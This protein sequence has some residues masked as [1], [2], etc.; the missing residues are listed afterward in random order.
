[1]RTY[2]G[3]NKFKMRTSQLKYAV[4]EFKQSLPDTMLPSFNKFSLTGLP[5]NESYSGHGDYHTSNLT[6]KKLD[7]KFFV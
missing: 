3:T 5:E 2:C 7:M 6:L 1:M 4:N